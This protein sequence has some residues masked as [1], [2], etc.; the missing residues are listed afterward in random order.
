[1]DGSARLRY[2]DVRRFL[3]EEQNWPG[4]N[5]Q[6]GPKT[7][8]NE[9]LGLAHADAKARKRVIDWGA[10]ILD[11]G[12]RKEEHAAKRRRVSEPTGAVGEVEGRAAVGAFLGD[13]P[14]PAAAAAVA[15]PPDARL[16]VGDEGNNNAGR[17]GEN[18]ENGREQQPSSDWLLH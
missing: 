17:G 18:A 3:I 9:M 16:N 6:A 13:A 1:V 14:D 5:V 15:V 11:D 10:Q 8:R 2:R 4:G 12:L 7:A